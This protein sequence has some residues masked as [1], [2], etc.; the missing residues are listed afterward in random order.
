MAN[1]KKIS[2]LTIARQSVVFNYGD[3]LLKN[4]STNYTNKG[5]GVIRGLSSHA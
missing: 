1:I 3:R 2:A 5:V 4:I